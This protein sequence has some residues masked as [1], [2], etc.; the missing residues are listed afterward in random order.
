MVG[1]SRRPVVGRSFLV[2]GRWRAIAAVVA[3]A[4]LL[5][6]GCGSAGPPQA[7]EVVVEEPLSRVAAPRRDGLEMAAEARENLI[8][9]S[10]TNH[11]AFAII[12]G[13]NCFG[14]IESNRPPVRRFH[15][16]IDE[17]QMPVKRLERGESIQGYL[18]FTEAGDLVGAR[19]VY[20]PLDARVEPQFCVIEPKER[21]R[22]DGL[23]ARD[24]SAPQP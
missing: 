13:P 10:L 23:F 16:G 17:Q 12:A 19:L 14:V 4:A 8:H 21:L 7:R 6:E 18:R 11:H 5:L 24:V 20:Y 3:L 2:W 22:P 9:V 1:A 15:P